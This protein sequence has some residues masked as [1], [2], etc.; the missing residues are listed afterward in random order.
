M[1]K[2]QAKIVVVQC[3]KCQ[4]S[5]TAYEKSIW[6]CDCG[7]SNAVLAAGS[8]QAYKEPKLKPK[9][10]GFIRNE[11]F[12][13]K[14]KAILKSLREPEWKELKRSSEGERDAAKEEK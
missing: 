10:R 9:E 1:A 14:A 4:V 3:T 7:Q 5:A 13:G 11:A 12:W 8:T 6:V 2:R